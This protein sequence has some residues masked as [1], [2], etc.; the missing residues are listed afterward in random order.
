MLRVFHGTDNRPADGGVG[1]SPAFGAE[2]GYDL[3]PL[4][5]IRGIMT[6][7]TTKFN[8]EKYKMLDLRLSYMLNISN[9]WQGQTPKRRF[10]IYWNVGPS[11]SFV[12]KRDRQ[13]SF[14]VWTSLQGT[15]R[16]MPKWDLYAEPLVQYNFKNGINPGNGQSIDNIK[17]G[18]M[19]GTRYHF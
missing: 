18:V 15:L 7:G 10:D 6:Y 9:V 4:A 11:L 2:V 8:N 5:S 3:H 1:I 12:S 14:G 13:Y 19:L 16:V 17:M